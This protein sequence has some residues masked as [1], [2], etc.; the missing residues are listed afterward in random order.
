MA[1]P[2][3]ELITGAEALERRDFSLLD[4]TI[5]D[6]MAANPLIEGEW[7][8]LDNATKKLKRGTGESSTPF[9]G[10]YWGERGRYD[11]RAINKCPILLWGNYEAYTKLVH[12]PNA[13]DAETPSV[14]GDRLCVKDITVDGVAGKRGL[15]LAQGAGH[16]WIVAY[17]YGPGRTTGEARIMR[18]EPFDQVI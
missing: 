18:R 1:V 14:I 13:P 12:N 15:K 7:L 8:E 4:S 2:Y 16:H 3:F 9:I 17:Y 6:P 5:L 10:Q 11:V